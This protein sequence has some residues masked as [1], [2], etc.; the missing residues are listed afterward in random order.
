[1]V[2]ITVIHVFDYVKMICWH[3]VVTVVMV[4]IVLWF[5]LSSIRGCNNVYGGGDGKIE[6]TDP[7]D[8]VRGLNG[9]MV[10]PAKTGNTIT[11][12]PSYMGEAC[13]HEYQVTHPGTSNSEAYKVVFDIMD[14]IDQNLPENYP[15]KERGLKWDEGCL[16]FIHRNEE[17]R[18]AKESAEA[19]K[20]DEDRTDKEVN[21]NLPDAD[22]S[23]TSN[24]SPSNGA[25]DKAKRKMGKANDS[26]DNS[27]NKDAINSAL[28]DEVMAEEVEDTIYKAEEEAA[29]VSKEVEDEMLVEDTKRIEDMQK[30]I[31]KME[32]SV[33]QMKE[34]N[35]IEDDEDDKDN[36]DD[37]KKN[38][39][40]NKHDDDEDED[41]DEDEYDE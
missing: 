23:A 16:N 14:K 32:E 2:C 30:N 40:K 21:M 17:E 11:P 37:S 27:A 41:E 3:V 31:D 1:M 33:E 5:L 26:S 4:V 38:K 8:P 18:R 22:E 9:E 10:I 19:K 13:R 20:D 7:D 6:S 39:K 24:K 29:R 15:A 34:N 25:N 35:G 36:K 28:A 12:I